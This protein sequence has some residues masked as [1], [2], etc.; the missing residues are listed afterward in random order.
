RDRVLLVAKA[1][2]KLLTSSHPPTLAFQSAGITGFNCAWPTIFFFFFFFLRLSLALLPRLECSGTILVHCNL[3]FLSSSD[4]PASASLSWDYRHVPPCLANFCIF[5]R[6]RVSSC[7]PG[8]SQTPDLE[9]I[10]LPQFWD[11]RCEPL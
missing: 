11:D 7:W 5:S 8:Q 1:V 3:Y 2:L 10:C 6:D 9:V 4:P